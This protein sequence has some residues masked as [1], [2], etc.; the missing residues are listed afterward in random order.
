MS[1]AGKP[2]PPITGET[3]PFWDG[4]AAAELRYQVCRECRHAQFYPRALCAGCGGVDLEWRRSQG[5]GRV[6]AVTVVERAPSAAFRAD[7]PY[8]IVLVDLDEGFRMMAN[9]VGDDRLEAAIGDR[10]RVVFER[11]GAMTVPQFTR[12]GAAPAAGVT[13]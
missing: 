8:V 3:Q 13:P 9:V 11:R 4:C 12:G 5:E 1:E 2:E 10:V 6:Y 7:V